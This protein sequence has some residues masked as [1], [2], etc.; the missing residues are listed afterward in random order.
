MADTPGATAPVR[1]T[2]HIDFHTINADGDKLF[3]IRENIPLEDA[4]EQASC[5]A[6]T[7]ADLVNQAALDGDTYQLWAA[8]YLADMSKA[9]LDS[10]C[11]A[12]YREKRHG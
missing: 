12:M 6:A 3:S 11:A 10:A 1:K 2:A 8:A 4:I 9:I 5:F 7:V